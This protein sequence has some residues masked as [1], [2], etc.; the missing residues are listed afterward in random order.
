M[1]LTDS[2]LW[3]LK[4]NKCLIVRHFLILFIQPVAKVKVILYANNLQ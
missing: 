3:L 2:F 4:Q 1:Y